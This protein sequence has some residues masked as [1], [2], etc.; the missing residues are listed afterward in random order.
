MKAYDCNEAD[1]V[2]AIDQSL[3]STPAR[4]SQF[5][6]FVNNYRSANPGVTVSTVQFTSPTNKDGINKMQNALDSSSARNQGGANAGRM[7]L[8]ITGY[9]SLPDTDKAALGSLYSTGATNLSIMTTGR[10]NELGMALEPRDRPT[11]IKQID[12]DQLSYQHD[13]AQAMLCRQNFT[14]LF[15]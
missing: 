13:F 12:I 4:Q 15:V 1:L 3:L 9:D 5:D 7:G 10:I 6:T 11:G 2:I 14:G 8:L